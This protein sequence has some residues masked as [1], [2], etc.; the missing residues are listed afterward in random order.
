MPLACIPGA[1]PNRPRY[2]ELRQ[3]LLAAIT[4]KDVQ[5]WNIDESKISL[6]ET[7]EWL[8]MERLCCPFLTFHLEISERP[9]YRLTITGPEGTAEFIQAEFEL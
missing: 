2:N 7:A 4:D 3:K 8:A 1:I 9:G 6:T 5:T